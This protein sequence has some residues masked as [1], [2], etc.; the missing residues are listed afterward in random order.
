MILRSNTQYVDSDHH[1]HTALA[2]WNLGAFPDQAAATTRWL[3]DS[4]GRENDDAVMPREQLGNTHSALP[5][6][7]T[8]H[9]PSV[10]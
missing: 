1:P 6:P 5:H 3:L 9:L 8:V 4:F 2:D 7:P 10:H